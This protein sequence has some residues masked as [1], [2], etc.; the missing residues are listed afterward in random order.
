MLSHTIFIF[1]WLNTGISDGFNYILI[2]FVKI[3]MIFVEM[4]MVVIYKFEL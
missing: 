3:G 1:K 2:A 4:E